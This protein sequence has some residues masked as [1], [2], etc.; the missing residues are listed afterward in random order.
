TNWLVTLAKRIQFVILLTAHH[1]SSPPRIIQPMRH[2]RE[3]VLVLLELALL[4]I[5]GVL[6]RK[7]KQVIQIA[8][9]DFAFVPADQPFGIL[10]RFDVDALAAIAVG[11]EL[12]SARIDFEYLDG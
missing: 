8:A 6:T 1:S 2:R 4:G 11:I 10:G 3:P 9:A 5:A 12:A 7:E